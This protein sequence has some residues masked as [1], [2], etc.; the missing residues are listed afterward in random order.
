MT[1]NNLF[2]QYTDM[3]L[4]VQHYILYVKNIFRLPPSYCIKQL[5]TRLRRRDSLCNCLKQ[6]ERNPDCHIVFIPFAQHTRTRTQHADIHLSR[7]IRRNRKLRTHPLHGSHI[8]SRLS[9]GMIFIS[10]HKPHRLKGIGH[11]DDDVGRLYTLCKRNDCDPIG[12]HR[13]PV[14]ALDRCAHPPGNRQ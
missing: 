13:F 6:L 14:K 7:K 11:H 10:L 9:S 2:T 3:I 12:G 1:E 4:N 8:D 5:I